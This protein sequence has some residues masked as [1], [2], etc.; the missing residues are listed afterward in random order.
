MSDSTEDVASVTRRRARS[1]VGYATTD[2][3]V[4]ETRNR[5]I[6]FRPWYIPHKTRP[7]ELAVKLITQV[8]TASE[9]W[10]QDS[11]LNL[12]EDAVARLRAAFEAHTEVARAGEE[13]EFLLIR[14]GGGL[15]RTSE[16]APGE[17]VRA[18]LQLLGRRDVLDRF[19]REDLGEQILSA[20]QGSIRLQELRTA[21]TQLREMLDG[22][23]VEEQPYQEWC[24]RHSWAFGNA[25]TVPDDIRRVSRTD[26]VDILMPRVLTGYRDI[27]ELKRPDHPVLLL[28][29]SRHNFFWS[30]PASEAI[31]QCAEYIEHLAADADRGLRGRPEIV[32]S[33]PRATIVIGRSRDWAEGGY[34]ALSRLNNH[35][36]GITVM[37]YDQLLAQGD[38]LI[39]LFSADE[40]TLR[41]HE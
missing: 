33:H 28:D 21:V 32:A 14:A 23:V 13:G 9:G 1:G 37:T 12:D 20:L 10:T 5:R 18:V 25:H 17:L 41:T 27:V 40:E 35:L 24:T 26:D 16:A 22:G 19:A 15:A 30:R 4:H 31:G 11:E 3:I 8:P 34:R 36:V 39:R 38:E 2:V 29:R 7:D 6:L